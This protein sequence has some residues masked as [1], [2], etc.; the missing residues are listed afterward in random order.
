MPA[1]I[2]KFILGALDKLMLPL[3]AYFKGRTD[4]QNKQY[5]AE[6]KGRKETHKI[7]DRVELDDDYHDSVR[8]RFDE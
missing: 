5:K 6:A 1:I 7:H 3:F 8:D 4:A 2:L